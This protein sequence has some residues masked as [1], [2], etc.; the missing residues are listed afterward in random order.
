MKKYLYIFTVILFFLGNT[1]ALAES[2]DSNSNEPATSVINEN[3]Q[4]NSENDQTAMTTSETH[5][6]I[7]K[8]SNQTSSTNPV[9]IKQAHVQ[10]I[11]W[12]NTTNDDQAYIGTIGKNLPLE[13]LRLAIDS[14][15]SGSIEYSAHVRNIGWQ[16]FVKDNQLAGTTGKALS[17]EA[18]KIQL[19]G[20]IANKYDIY[21]RVH[22]QNFGWLD[23]AKNGEEAG[24]Q[25]YAFHA[26]AI[27]LRLV[28]KGQPA[29]G[30]TANPFKFKVELNYQ[31]H[32]RNIGWM[33]KVDNG[34]V[35]GTTGKNLSLEALKLQL[36]TTNFGN[37]VARAH[38]RNIGWQDW[39][40]SSN[41]IGTIGKALPIEAIQFNLTDRLA[42]TYD[43]YYRVHVQNV[44]WLGWTKN[45]EI[46]GSTGMAYH[47]E[48]V[49]LKLIEKGQTTPNIGE[50]SMLAPSTIESVAN[51]QQQTTS[52]SIAN[53][54]IIGTVGKNLALLGFSTTVINDGFTG[55]IQYQVSIDAKTWS[56]VRS[57]GT[58]S[59]N[60]PFQMVKVQLT[61]EIANHFNIYYRVHVQNIGWLGWTK[62]GQV[63]GSSSYN[64]HIEAIQLYLLR[65]NAQS[66]INPSENAFVDKNKS[67][68]IYL[69]AGH[70][71]SDPGAV[72][73][74]L[75]E[76]DITLSVARKVRDKLVAE[77]YQVIMRRDDDS[78]TDLVGDPSK[79]ISGIATNANSSN[80]DIFVSIHVNSFGNGNAR[81]IETYWYEYSSAYPPAI[82]A[83]YHNNPTRLAN[84]SRLA[85][86]IQRHLISSTNAY[87]RGVNR[88]TFAVLRETRMPA[89]LIETGFIDNVNESNQLRNDAYQNK[90]AQGIVEGI[91]EYFK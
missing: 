59:S 61:G 49:E 23:W 9:I 39:I 20:D 66:P 73:N 28:S 42:Q 87:N 33:N 77:N 58:L 18:I 83:Q 72:A 56:S 84:S 60:E 89:V 32:V 6:T 57:N 41:P 51:V 14:T 91:I 34:N 81:G 86:S 53:N 15:I 46:S 21:Y 69:D 13:A 27:E 24:S 67:R 1:Y 26:E 7:S 65:N 40:E 36:S 4:N 62:N 16:P 19:T 11:G 3:S 71:G 35:A 54:G 10:N 82:N 75:R 30:N 8:E 37:I 2:I 44:G 12:M 45:G 85:N 68:I 76:K 80:A 63:A 55:G 70:G 25:G 29:P 38:V 74:G 64:Y 17:I 79:G 43:I 78:Y 48:A 52:T 88:N 22:V 50:R 31:A 5:E 47:I 90:L